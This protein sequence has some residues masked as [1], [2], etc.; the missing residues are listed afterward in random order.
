MIL[1]IYSGYN[2][3]YNIDNDVKMSLLGSIL[4]NI[5]TETLREEEGGTYSPAATAYM[6]SETGVWNILYQVQ[7]NAA[8]QQKLMDRAHDELMKLLQ[9]GATEE[10]FK[11]VKEA[12]MK[13][14]EINVRNNGYWLNNLLSYARG[15][16]DISGHKAAIENLTLADFNK[17]MKNLYN[18]DN[19]IQV[20]MEGVEESK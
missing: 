18:G 15:I 12:E 5:Y 2:I 20:I 13:Q 6:D 10:Q 7:T 9:N 16:D 3:P 8:M 14:Y 17:F 19:R 4:G 11:K 1:D